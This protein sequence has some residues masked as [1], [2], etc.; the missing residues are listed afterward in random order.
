MR[1][2]NEIL[3]KIRK[4]FPQLDEKIFTI[5]KIIIEKLKKEN[6]FFKFRE[7]KDLLMPNGNLL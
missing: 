7:S 5:Q 4:I 2:M 1:M 3:L 6:P